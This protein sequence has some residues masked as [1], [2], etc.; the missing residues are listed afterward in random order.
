MITLSMESSINYINILIIKISNCPREIETI[1]MIKKK[2]FK[3][4]YLTD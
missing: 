2:Q 4:F 1:S 3:K